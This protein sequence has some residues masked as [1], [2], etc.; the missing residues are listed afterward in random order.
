[1]F[2]NFKIAKYS[3]LTDAEIKQN[4]QYFVYALIFSMVVTIIL[5][6]LNALPYD[7]ETLYG[8][9]IVYSI[10]GLLVYYKQSRIAAGWIIFDF[11]SS[12]FYLLVYSPEVMLNLPAI[13]MALC[14]SVFYYNGFVSLLKYNAL[15]KIK[16]NV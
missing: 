16:K 10:F 8:T 5:G 12:K 2:D 14:I 6:L 11:L 13:S 15:K 4:I 3:T 7:S 9:F 1:M